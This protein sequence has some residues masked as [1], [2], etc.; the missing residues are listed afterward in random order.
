MIPPAFDIH[1]FEPPSGPVA[2]LHQRGDR[3]GIVLEDDGAENVE[4]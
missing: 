3:A 1:P 2:L 4:V